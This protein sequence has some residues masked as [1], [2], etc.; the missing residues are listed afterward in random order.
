MA[1]IIR[2]AALTGLGLLLAAPAG[3]EDVLNGWARRGSVYE[4][5]DMDDG[6][7]QAC[8]ALCRADGQCRSWVWTRSDLTGS[9]EMCALLSSVPTAYP[10]PGQATGLSPRIAERLDMAMDRAPSS[11]E[12]RALHEVTTP[13]H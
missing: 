4:R 1:R 12:S 11:R 3:A 5:I 7:P 2:L 9:Y 10:A 13:G 8:A 6:T